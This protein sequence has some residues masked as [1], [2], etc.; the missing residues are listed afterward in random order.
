MFTIYSHKEKH[1]VNVPSSSLDKSGNR[2]I[3]SILFLDERDG[4]ERKT[5]YLIIFLFP[6]VSH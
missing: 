2:N 6:V 5:H 3:R 4:P 1:M